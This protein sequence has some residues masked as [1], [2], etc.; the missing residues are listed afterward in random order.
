MEVFIPKFIGY[1]TGY[2]FL[3]FTVL[4]KKSNYTFF[5]EFLWPKKK[6]TSREITVIFFLL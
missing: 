4:F 6:K 1:F 2:L 5:C 3:Y